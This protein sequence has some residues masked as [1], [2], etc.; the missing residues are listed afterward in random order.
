MSAANDCIFAAIEFAF[1]TD[2]GLAFLKC[3][4]QGEFD[5]IRKEWPDAPEAVFIGADSSHPETKRLLSGDE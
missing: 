3:W 2:E 4:Y 1:E 5:T